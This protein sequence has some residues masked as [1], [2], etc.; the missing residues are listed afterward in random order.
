[1][2]L[3]RGNA[4]AVKREG[5]RNVPK[6]AIEIDGS[7]MAEAMDVLA[8][9][10]QAA[11]EW[12]GKNGAGIALSLVE[13]SAPRVPESAVAPESKP[14]PA[15]PRGR[16]QK[17]EDAKVSEEAPAEARAAD[18]LPIVKPAA[19]PESNEAPAKVGGVDVASISKETLELLKSKKRPKDAVS[20]LYQSVTQD[21]DTLIDLC[22][23][24]KPEVL[25]FERCPDLEG[26]VRHAHSILAT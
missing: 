12:S 21:L 16:R 8:H 9:I 22:V 19:K 4:F 13:A 10:S 14:P 23:K 6:I 11:K 18:V 25:V 26:N 7:T 15:T 1:M 5:K 2:A 17:P 20:I 24:L 3:G